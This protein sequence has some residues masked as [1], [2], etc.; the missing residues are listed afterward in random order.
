MTKRQRVE[1]TIR[2]QET[3]RVPLYDLV[4]CDAAFEYFGGGRIPPLSKETAITQ[5]VEKLVGRAISSFCDMT[6]S[7][8][9]GP[10]I[11]EEWVDEYGDTWHASPKEKTIWISKRKVRNESDAVELIHLLIANQRTARK[12]LI[13]NPEPFR[14]RYISEFLEI[15]SRIGDTVNLYAQHGTGLDDIRYRLGF[16][17]FCYVEHDRPDIISEYLEE[18]TNLHVAICHAVA[19]ISLSPAVL[20]YGDIACKGRLLHS[21]EFL[22]REFFPRLKRIN[23]AWHEHGFACLFHSDGYLMDVMDDLISAGIDG[24][25]PIETIAGMDLREIKKKYGEKIFLAGGI[26]MSQLLSLGTP[27]EVKNVCRQA[28]RDAYPGYFLGSTTELDNSTK[29]ENIIAM[30]EVALQGIR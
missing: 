9:F 8:G 3:D 18:T 25:N 20:T 4:R 27:E 28:I 30:H 1:M 2:R 19:D 16:E 26:D 10:F 12:E 29:L 11:E 5:K 24:L 7:V 21:P 6:R 17:L 23:D 22:R 15:Q 14:Q 13:L